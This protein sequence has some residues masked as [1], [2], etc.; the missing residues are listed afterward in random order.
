MRKWDGQ[1]RGTEY[2]KAKA[3]IHSCRRK[4]KKHRREKCCTLNIR[5]NMKK[6]GLKLSLSLSRL[7]GIE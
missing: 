7:E 3:L 2:K 1:S 5:G 4:W 6:T